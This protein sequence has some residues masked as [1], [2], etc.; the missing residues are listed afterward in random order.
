MNYD[1][2]TGLKLQCV[3]TQFLWLSSLHLVLLILS[4]CNSFRLNQH[5]KGNQFKQRRWQNTW[6]QNLRQLQQSKISVWRWKPFWRWQLLLL[7]CHSH[8]RINL[9]VTLSPLPPPPSLFVG[10]WSCILWHGALRF[11]FECL[12]VV[13][14]SRKGLRG[15]KC[16]E[17]IWTREVQSKCDG[18]VSEYLSITPALTCACWHVDSVWIFQI[19]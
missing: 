15:S 19:L 17:R 7:A 11:Q 4:R 5:F 18:A 1:S 14:Q 16:Q 9:S 12:S 6:I 10:Q 8:S 3:W 2:L 13:W